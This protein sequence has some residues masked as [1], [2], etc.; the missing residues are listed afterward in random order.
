MSDMS[1]PTK[2]KSQFMNVQGGEKKVMK[3]I[4][5]VALSTA[6]AFSMFASVA[7][8]ETA[9]ATPQQAFDALAA[10]GILNGYPDGQAHLE[11][12][13]TRAEFAKIVTKLFGLTEVTGKLSYKDKGYTA[14]N[15]AVPY[16]EA[17]T[18][19]NL[20]QGQDTVK[21]I[22]N[23][24][25]KV[26]VEEV[27]AVLFR[28]LKLETPT[29]TDNSASA[30]A[31]G[32]AQAVINA[33][34]VAQTTNFKANATR[35]LVVE[36][37][38]AVDQLSVKP[39]L[40]VATAVATN[41]TTVVVTFSDKT[42]QTV[43]L[44]T[45]LVQGVETTISFKHLEKDYTAKVTLEAPKV[46]S[47]EAINGKQV[48]VKFNRAI[49][50]D[51]LIAADGTLIDTAVEIK[52]LSG[53]KVVTET[54][55]RVTLNA[56]S[57][58]ATI[59][60]ANT[61][62]FSGQYGFTLNK[63]VKTT[64][65]EEVP[66]FTT[67]LNVNDTVA[68]AFVSATSAAKA[69]TTKVV[70]KFSEPVLQAGAIV[71]VDGAPATVVQSTYASSELVLTTGTTL[72]SGKEYDISLLNVKDFAGNAIT[73]NPFKTKFTVV[74]DVAGPVIQSLVVDGE[75]NIK[76][77]FDKVVDTATLANNARL[78]NP[79]NGSLVTSYNFVSS[80]N[81]GKT[82]LLQPATPANISFGSTSNT[83]T[84]N[85]VVGT[86]VLD[87][88]GNALNAAFTQ[89]VTFTKDVT[90]PVVSTVVYKSTGVVVTFSEN[91]T[92]SGAV[93]GITLVNDSTGSI[94]AGVADYDAT[95]AEVT[96]PYS[97]AAGSYTLR[98]PAGLVKDKADSP[99][100]SAASL[101]T[102]SASATSTTDTSA[103]KFNV[104]GDP[105]VAVVTDL[106][107]TIGAEQTVSFVVYDESGI[108]FG[109]VLE[110]T[111]YTLDNKALPA[112]SYVT[113]RLTTDTAATETLASK[114]TVTVHIPGSGLTETKNY[115]LVISN[116][117]DKA[118]NTALPQVSAAFKLFEG[119][120]PVF[121]SAAISAGDNTTLV[122]GFSEAV[123]NV[124]VTDFTFTINN[125]DASTAANTIT[126]I[127]S[128]TDKGKY[129]VSFKT[130][131]TDGKLYIDVT[132][133]DDIYVADTT[134]ANGTAGT[135]NL[136]TTG[137]YQ[138]SAKIKDASTTNIIDFADT[139]TGNAVVTGTSI[140]VR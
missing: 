12:D 93:A 121:N 75:K 101:H 132:G 25:G 117:K 24:N 120:K 71:Y 63:V 14:T 9:K 91:V 77:T 104:T 5:S 88:L 41:P 82:V 21:G 2:E 6:M 22:F 85:F 46:L 126:E 78:L 79:A 84:G 62:V 76:I 103:P 129:Y 45:A 58:E 108:D 65:A 1:Y 3:K 135:L 116:I 127:T 97:L 28:A 89:A 38:Y 4:L 50:A 52:E 102:F 124:D 56:D 39:T 7:F 118:G 94:V 67:L 13:L 122:L 18:A 137:V 96:I 80:S 131:V 48:V 70:V 105:A 138:I 139:T 64:A 57:T 60:A 112:N 35:S 47:V 130:I 16:I 36:T 31:K 11:K 133:A 20:M 29:T 51:T 49:D 68:P 128:G 72:T 33:G 125:K 119:V 73:P 54:I 59:T 87:T 123:R 66:A 140:D 42:T 106:P 92:K 15:W 90:A 110:A 40:T 19:A 69:T 34:L 86:G 100:S 98:L 8:G 83:Y 53:A 27:A 99:N 61:E 111:N 23:Y 44:T 10:K 114:R 115:T 95:G 37:A 81:G 26:T 30:W 134:T 17:V 109:T 32:Y 43:T 55:A 74:S 107:T 113:T 136:N